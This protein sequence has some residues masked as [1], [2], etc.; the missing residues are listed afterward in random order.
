[1]AS[2]LLA[3][4]TEHSI[5]PYRFGGKRGGEGRFRSERRKNV[6]ENSRLHTSGFPVGGR[7]LFFYI[8]EIFGLAALN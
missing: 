1:M 6:F 7:R 3:M 2:N 5:L 4:A 8:F